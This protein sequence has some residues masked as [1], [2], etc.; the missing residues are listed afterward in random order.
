MSMWHMVRAAL[1]FGLEEF[2]DST[3]LMDMMMI[4]HQVSR[5][6]G[7]SVDDMPRELRSLLRAIPHDQCEIHGGVVQE[8]GPRDH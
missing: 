4:Q 6:D 5:G 7:M 8:N 2:F 1:D 3:C